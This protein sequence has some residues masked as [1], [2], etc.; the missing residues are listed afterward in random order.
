MQRQPVRRLLLERKGQCRRHPAI[1]AFRPAV[2]PRSGGRSHAAT[3]I[4]ALLAWTDAPS[5]LERE[6]FHDAMHMAHGYLESLALQVGAVTAYIEVIEANEAP[7]TGSWL[8]NP[9]KGGS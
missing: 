9:R 4:E 6:R 2:G 8:R 5:Y 7:R 3:V 1:L